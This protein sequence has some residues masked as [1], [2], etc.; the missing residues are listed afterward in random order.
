MISSIRAEFRKLFT[1]RS[2]YLIAG[3]V[4]LMVLFFAF[5]IEGIKANPE[6]LASPTKLSTSATSALLATSALISLVG[7]LLMAHEYRYNTIMFTLTSSNSRSKSLLAKIISVS[8]FAV[9][10]SLIIGVLSPTLTYL[11][12]LAGGHMLADQ[13]I[14]V[15]DLLWRCLFYGWGYSMAALLLANLIRNQVGAI[16]AIFIIPV[17]VEGLLSLLL[18][19]N[20]VYLPFTA[21]S[22]VVMQSGGGQQGPPIGNSLSPGKGALVF[23]IYLLIGWI[24]AWVLFLRRDAN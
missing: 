6:S 2:T 12:I 24:V 8:I 10:M 14:P 5:Y 11:G 4:F 22:Q 23:G 17:A 7:L 18:K 19:S 20:A 3:F 21:L 15:W 9:F 16:A 1:V 13:V